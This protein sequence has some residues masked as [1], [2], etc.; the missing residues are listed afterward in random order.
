MTQEEIKQYIRLC[1]KFE[2]EC[3]RVR[4]ILTESKKRT[5]DPNDIR[6]AD[7]F[8]IEHNN[9]VWEGRETWS[10]GG[11]K[12]HNGMFDLNYLTMTDDELRQ[13]VERENLEWDKE[14]KEMKEKGE[15]LSKRL[16]RKQYELLKKEFENGTEI[17]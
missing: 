1:D 8:I 15:E 9:V 2:D 17:H 4:T 10:Y 14:Q 13:V 6:W 12:W 3:Y 16:R 7:K 11:E 5:I